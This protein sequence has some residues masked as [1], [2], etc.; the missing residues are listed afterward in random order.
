MDKIKIDFDYFARLFYLFMKKAE[1]ESD[2]YIRDEIINNQNNESIEEQYREDDSSEDDK[3][4]YKIKHGLDNDF[5]D[6]A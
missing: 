3:K 6:D 5:Y 1:I 2:D 4:E